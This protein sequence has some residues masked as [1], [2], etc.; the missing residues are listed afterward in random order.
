MEKGQ[1]LAV[2]RAS[3]SLQTV[4]CYATVLITYFVPCHEQASN[5][6]KMDTTD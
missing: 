6:E 4:V 1:A 3:D 2:G 5:E